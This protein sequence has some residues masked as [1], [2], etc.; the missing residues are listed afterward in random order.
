MDGQDVKQ[1]RVYK[2]KEVF[3]ERDSKRNRGMIWK[4]IRE[5]RT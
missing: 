2:E 3:K 1:G 4:K 5:R